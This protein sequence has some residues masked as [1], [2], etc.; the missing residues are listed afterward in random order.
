MTVMQVVC[1][2]AFLLCSLQIGLSIEL[3]H[4]YKL[5][6]LLDIVQNVGFRLSYSELTRLEKKEKKHAVAGG[7]ASL[8]IVETFYYI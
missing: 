8:S 1:P 5:R 3:Y 4:N 7:F 2:R 6:Y